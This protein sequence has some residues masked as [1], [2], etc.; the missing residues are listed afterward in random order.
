MIKNRREPF[1]FHWTCASLAGLAFLA[2]CASSSPSA[3]PNKTGWIKDEV[4]D[5]YVFGYPLVLMGVAR[6]AAVG[7]EP[8]QAPINTLRHAQAL[9][10]IG[11]ANPTRPSLDTLDSTGW[12]DIGAEPVILSLPDSHGR[13][14][15]ARVLDMWTNVVWSTSS[16]FETRASGIKAQSIA[17]VSPEWKGDLPKNV[18]RVDVPTRNAWVSVRIQSN[19]TRDLTAVRKLQRAIRAVP[20]SVYVGDTHAA[21]V[22]PPR[23]NSAETANAA[24]TTP[25]AQVAALDANGFFS[26]LADALPDNPPTPADPHA[27]K[28]LS[29]FGVTPG[30]PVNLPSATAVVNAGLSDGRERVATPPTNVLSANGW[31]WFGDGVGNYGPD[32]ALRA[33]AASTQPGIGTKDDE[34]R[35]VVS[36]DSDGHALNGANRYVIH[37]APN[38]LPPVR[39]FWSITA[40]T[41]DGALGESAPAHLAV[42][43]RNGAR[44]N[45]D[46]SLDVIVSSTRSKGGNWLPAPRSDLQLV[47]RLYAPKPQATDGSWQPPAVVRQ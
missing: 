43:D 16:Q 26:R 23:S 44:R 4:A 25:A 38:E 8:G 19:G 3:T 17:F 14:V 36:Q 40:Y 20:L 1:S 34:V 22:A 5:S 11:A 21:Q 39:G 10:P 9:P 32:Y 30:E 24:A 15:D 46:G 18:K 6:D 41:K 7:T 2:G 29:D 12:L 13:Y 47:L 27:L 31:N 45:R 28:I 37:F 42:G 35:A 33:Y